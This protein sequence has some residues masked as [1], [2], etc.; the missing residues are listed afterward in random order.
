M[1]LNNFKLPY[2]T[3]L[4][5]P[6]LTECLGVSSYAHMVV[7]IAGPKGI[8]IVHGSLKHAVQCDKASSWDQT[9]FSGIAD[10][11]KPNGLN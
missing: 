9:L 5:R 3:L 7:K 10:N 4:D 6:W 11:A 1:K 2:K 8:I